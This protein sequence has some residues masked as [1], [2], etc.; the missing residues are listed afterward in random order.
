MRHT[1]KKRLLKR[2]GRILTTAELAVFLGVA[3]KTVKRYVGDGMPV[4]KRDESGGRGGYQIDSAQAVAWLV[5]REGGAGEPTESLSPRDQL[6]TTQN[7]SLALDVR[8]KEGELVPWRDAL[9]II[10]AFVDKAKSMLLR[11]PVKW[12]QDLTNAPAIHEVTSRDITTAL[13]E[14]SQWEPE[15]NLGPSEAVEGKG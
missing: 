9:A 10:G 11:L 12:S 4:S 13:N 6:Y 7:R 3:T 2:A 8:A 14:L 15:T 5:T 1:D